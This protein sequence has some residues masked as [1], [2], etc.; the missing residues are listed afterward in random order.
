MDF[1]RGMSVLG[2]E[3]I[4]ES[5]KF[6]IILFSL[7]CIFAVGVTLTGCG[8][9]GGGGDGTSVQLEPLAI[10][11]NNAMQVTASALDAT[12][13]VTDVGEPGG[14]IGVVAD[15][16]NSQIDL[17]KVIRAQLDRF[18]DLAVQTAQLT[19]VGM[20][21]T[22]SCNVGGSVTLS[23]EIASPDSSTFTSGDTMTVAAKNCDDGDG[24]VLNGTMTIVVV[25]AM[26]M[27]DP[28]LTSDN[29]F[30]PPY[31]YTFNV[32][33]TNLSMKETATGS[34]VSINGDMTLQED[35]NDGM[36]IN[37][38]YS[39]NSLQLKTPDTTDALTGYEITSTLDQGSN[40]AYTTKSMGSLS[41][42][43]LGGSIDFHT[44]TPFT[45][46]N[47]DFPDSG[48]MVIT[49]ATV[50]DGVGPSKVTVDAQNSQCVGLYV[51]PNGDGVTSQIFTTWESLPSG[52]PVDCPI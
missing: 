37:S 38:I 49:G 31:K 26:G 4:M 2:K 27:I 39:G 41:S 47:S 35:S 48:Q 51:D 1:V 29:L 11:T 15:Q 52:V 6:R 13:L 17:L 44:T 30:L 5:P 36:L 12:V 3:E 50:P 34:T 10:D 18:P 9:G 14:P 46:F 22:Y 24:M 21:E 42:T 33:M 16:E 40:N 20:S 32:T 19:G 8:G 45:G 23:G 28:N 43:K 7:S 25:S